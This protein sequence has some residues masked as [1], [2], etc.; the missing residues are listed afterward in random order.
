MKNKLHP[1]AKWQFR[2]SVSIILLIFLIIIYSAFVLPF[3]ISSVF[4]GGNQSPLVYF[5]LIPI[6]CLIVVIILS[7]IYA[8]MS[9]NR[10]FYE[11]TPDNLKIEKGIVVKRYSNIPYSRIQNVDIRRGILARMLGYSSVIIQTAGYSGVSLAEG[12]LPAVS[13]EAA[14]K[15]REFVMKKIRRKHK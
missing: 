6:I 9:Y 2:I 3:A 13:M 10:W 8:R 7:E 15:I 5:V 14:E 1:G 11:F 4:L 12:N